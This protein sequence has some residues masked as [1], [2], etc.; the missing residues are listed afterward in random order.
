M[1]GQIARAVATLINFVGILQ[2]GVSYLLSSKA[3]LEAVNLREH[4]IKHALSFPIK[5]RQKKILTQIE[6]TPI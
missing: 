4:V 2:F 6:K 1:P 3:L 5:N